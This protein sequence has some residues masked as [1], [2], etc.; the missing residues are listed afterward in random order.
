MSAA[1][2]ARGRIHAK[3]RLRAGQDP[4]TAG[5]GCRWQS[6]HPWA[7]LQGHGRRAAR[8]RVARCQSQ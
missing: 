7:G 8:N 6:S 1:A 5:A 4:P 2:A 3:G